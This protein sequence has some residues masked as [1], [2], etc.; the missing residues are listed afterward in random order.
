M[1][2]YKNF[3]TLEKISKNMIYQNHIRKRDQKNIEQLFARLFSTEDG[4]NVLA[5]LQNLTFHRA[6]NPSLSEADLR[7][8]EGQRSLLGVILK[9]IERGRT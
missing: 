7:H 6:A 4:K 2:H 3:I 1:F 9:L 5:Y 8:M